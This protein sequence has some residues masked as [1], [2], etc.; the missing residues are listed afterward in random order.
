MKIKITFLNKKLKDI[1]FIDLK[2][3][4]FKLK[5]VKTYWKKIKKN[6]R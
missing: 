4:K 2:E 6:E 5:H 1:E 3:P